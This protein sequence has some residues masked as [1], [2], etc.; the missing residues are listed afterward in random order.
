MSRSRVSFASF[1]LIALALA[2]LSACT[3]GPDPANDSFRI[4]PINDTE[5]AGAG[6]S[7]PVVADE[8]QQHAAPPAVTVTETE[9]APEPEFDVRRGEGRLAFEETVLDNG[10]RVVSLEDHSAP[11]VAV[12]LWYHV[13]SKDENPERQGFAHMFE[14]MMFRGTD[15]LGPKDHFDYIRRT[16]G[17]ANA[18]T[19]FDQTVYVQEL[20]ANQLEM[21]LWLEAERMS[22]LKIDEGGFATERKVVEEER[23]LGLNQPFGDV[24]E[25]LLTGLF[26]E[27][28]YRWSPIGQIEHLRAS[29]ADDIQKFWDTYY[30]PNNATLVVVGDVTHDEVRR[31]A[32]QSFGWI[33]RCDDPPR[34]TVAEPEQTE[35]RKVSIKPE[36]GPVPI[37]G[38]AFQAVP[39]G[40][41]D[42]VA[43]NLLM[44]I[45]GGGESSRLYIDMVRRKEVAVMGM[46]MYAGLEQA[47]FA[48]LVGITMPLGDTDPI[49]DAIWEQIELVKA[50]GVTEDELAKVRKQVMRADVTESLTIA[51]KAGALG[52]AAVLYGDTQEA[53]ERIRRMEQVG[54]EDLQR[55]ANTYL[56]RERATEVTIKPGI[57]SMLRSVL[58]MGGGDTAAEEED[59]GSEEEVEGGRRAAATGPKAGALP[60]AGY[61]LAPPVAPPLA[62]AI[63]IS[64]EEHVLDNGLKVV[65]I[66]NHEVPF[67]TMSLRLRTGAFTE[68]PAFPGTAAMA[69]SMVTRGTY[70]RDAEALALELEKNAINLGASAGHDSASISVSSLT[71]DA[72]R[73]LRLMSEVVQVPRFDA[74]EFKTLRDQMLTGKTI[75]EK[76]PS[77]IAGRTLNEALWGDHPYGRPSDGTADD[78]K[79]LDPEALSEWWARFVRPELGVLYVSGDLDTDEAV[80]IA[81]RFLGGW[82]A[83][84]AP[85]EVPLP[86]FNPPRETRITLVDKPGAIQSEIRAAHEG[87]GYKHPMF[88]QGVVLSQIFGGAFTSRLNDVIRVQKGLTYGASG[89]LNSRRFGGQFTVR[90]FTKTPTTGETV[91]AVIDEVS[92]MRD[93]APSDKELGDAVSYISGS[94][95]GQ[96]ETPQAV[97]DRLWALELNDLPDGWWND[98]L[99]RISATTSEDVARAARTL[100][101][102]E[103]LLIVVVGSADDVKE[104]LEAIAPVEVITE[105]G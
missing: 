58:S 14:H 98:Y 53:N 65:V 33:P 51:S 35:L 7:A 24:L 20:P 5:D 78:L 69:A 102:P 85:I 49:I 40:H 83:E 94:F 56:V 67:V 50:E 63:D 54:I 25:K 1:A 26:K 101:D 60:P 8:P 11:I 45:I 15:R 99:Q 29:T 96:L 10:L 52:Q 34:V 59:D 84:V 92:R 62:A 16:G 46:G 61:P 72:E 55:V 28:P 76:T 12:Q 91:Q 38:I 32:H 41:P 86:D 27:H 95:A 44:S 6:V 103:R 3:S 30:V 97:A 68:D 104:E 31:L 87:I 89:G 64:G 22:A 100:L 79:N 2:P 74:K 82:E 81:D 77:A 21:V 88:A 42:A 75:E 9:T 43:L 90:T 57:G 4:V 18:Y 48:A 105:G 93:E 17:N 70:V 37:A 23:R 39:D 19:S 13:G 73:A 47:G 80:R 66:E 71:E 36:N